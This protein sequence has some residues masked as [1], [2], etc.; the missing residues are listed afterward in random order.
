MFRYINSELKYHPLCSK[1]KSW[2]NVCAYVCMRVKS[3]SISNIWSFITQ[4]LIF[5]ITVNG[6]MA[7]TQVSSNKCCDGDQK[8]FEHD[9]WETRLHLNAWM[10]YSPTAP[11]K[12]SISSSELKCKMK[13]AIYLPPKAESSKCPVLYWLSGACIHFVSLEWT[14]RAT[15]SVY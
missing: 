5:L 15:I 12:N 10:K 3:D 9:R 14:S 1:V 6:A 8:V 4:T 2:S 11:N 13:F 7:L